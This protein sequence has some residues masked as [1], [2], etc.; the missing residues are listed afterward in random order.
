MKNLDKSGIL[1]LD[2]GKTR[3]INELANIVLSWH[4]T[5]DSNSN[6]AI[7]YVPFTIN[8][9]GSYQNFTES[10]P[11]ELIKIGYHKEFLDIEEGVVKFLNFFNK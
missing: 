11:E 10:D 1:N 9:K 7:E 3:T 4:K 6:P 5:K 2:S 8:L